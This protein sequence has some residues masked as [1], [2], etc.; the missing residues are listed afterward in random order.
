M[1]EASGPRG[2]WGREIDRKGGSHKKNIVHE[3]GRH[4]KNPENTKQNSMHGTGIGRAK[5]E[6]TDTVAANCVDQDLT[7]SVHQRTTGAP[8]KEAR[9]KNTNTYL[10]GRVSDRKIQLT[11]RTRDVVNARREL[12]GMCTWS[13]KAGGWRKST[14]ATTTP[15]KEKR[16]VQKR[17][18]ESRDQLRHAMR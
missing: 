12:P 5:V 2:V 1:R 13:S 18:V 7:R 6:D 8:G 14:P 11:S 4:E 9:A 17:A 10:Q 16:R 15:R 3:R